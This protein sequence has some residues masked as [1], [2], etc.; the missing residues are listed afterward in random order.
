MRKTSYVV[1]FVLAA[2]LLVFNISAAFRTDWR[3]PLL[4][5]VVRGEGSLSHH[6]A[7]RYGLAFR[8]ARDLYTI[9]NPSDP[10]GPPQIVYSDFECR[11]FPMSVRDHCEK[12]NRAFCVAWATASY[13]YE[14]GI[15]F[16]V[17][18]LLAIVF[19]VSTHSRRRRIWKAVAVLIFIASLFPMITFAVISD[20]FRTARFWEFA[21]ARPGWAYYL[22]II[23]WIA[24]FVLTGAVVI[25]GVAAS[26]GHRWAAGRRAYR[27]I[28]G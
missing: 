12:G 27:P 20:L 2:A 3:A 9:P 18:A 10:T 26:K 7:V 16:N 25:N 8:C 23:C 17:L 19:G 4:L 13:L 5:L 28:S 1:S 14:V 22:S 21:R 6:V 11:P 15:G 24:G